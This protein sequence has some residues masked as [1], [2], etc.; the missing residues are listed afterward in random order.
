[1]ANDSVNGTTRPAPPPPPKPKPQPKP[2]APK[3]PQK[4]YHKE[5]QDTATKDGKLSEDDFVK[6][7]K[8]LGLD[9]KDKG[10]LQKLYEK[11]A[12]T[13]NANG[14]HGNSTMNESEFDKMM[15][16]QG[17]K[18]RLEPYTVKSGDGFIKIATQ[19][20][21]PHDWQALAKANGL[22]PDGVIQPGQSLKIP[23]HWQPDAVKVTAPAP[24]GGSGNTSSKGEAKAAD[25]I[26]K[27][28]I[29]GVAPI[30]P[31]M[32]QKAQSADQTTLKN[33]QDALAKVPKDDPQ[34]KALEGKVKA[35]QDAFKAKYP[36]PNE[37]RIKDKGLQDN[38]NGEIKN[39]DHNNPDP[40][41]VKDIVNQ[42]KENGDPTSLARA[43][44]LS[45]LIGPDAKHL[46]GDTKSNLINAL[47]DNTDTYSDLQKAVGGCDSSPEAFR[48]IARV[49]AAGI[50]DNHPNGCYQ[51]AHV[52]NT[53]AAD[54]VS[55]GVRSDIHQ[56]FD[57]DSDT[58]DFNDALG[59]ANSKQDYAA[60]Q[61]LAD[62]HGTHDGFNNAQGAVLKSV[63][64]NYDTL[65]KSPN[66]N[67]FKGH[68]RDAINDNDNTSSEMRAAV[69]SMIN[70]D[71]KSLRDAKGNPTPMAKALESLV[72]ARLTNYG[73][74][75][76]KA[77]RDHL[78]S[79]INSPGYNPSGGD[80]DN[81]LKNGI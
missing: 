37:A 75:D 38:I 4:A 80:I 46:S 49:A 9:A 6:H 73:D 43:D 17:A 14:E 13:D 50:D 59:K 10:S 55:Q 79:L 23:D 27:A 32:H 8:D 25:T 62:F 29:D 45:A 81:A 22:K 52:L 18:P 57:D 65:S 58:D 20:G 5:F 48:T 53:A 11:Y 42:L 69:E 26:N 31:D 21:H 77:L 60:L 64:D 16:S 70:G 56:A 71:P 76:T 67:D 72:N 1:M 63:V 39:L 7:A 19:L 28:T 78:T 47:Q 74:G 35:L 15:S 68:I 54:G 24:T 33:A 40:Q 51:M 41:S 66:W 61:A 12:T 3:D 34:H 2:E 30:K 36:T 44:G